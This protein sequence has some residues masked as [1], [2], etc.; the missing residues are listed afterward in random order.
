M[1]ELQVP[2]LRLGAA[3]SFTEDSQLFSPVAAL[4]E[5]PHLQHSTAAL[6][7]HIL[8]C[9]TRTLPAAMPVLA[10]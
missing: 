6:Q 2:D 3:A 5:S 10:Y 1:F 8:P 7:V 9:F 4:L